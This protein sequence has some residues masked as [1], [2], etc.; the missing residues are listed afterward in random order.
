MDVIQRLQHVLLRCRKFPRRKKN[1]LNFSNLLP[2]SHRIHCEIMMLLTNYSQQ[3]TTF[4]PAWILEESLKCKWIFYVSPNGSVGKGLTTRGS[5][6]RERKTTC[7][8]E[9]HFC[10]LLPRTGRECIFVI[11]HEGIGT[12]QAVVHDTMTSCNGNALRI[13]GPFWGG[14]GSPHKVLMMCTFDVFCF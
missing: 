8:L 6:P 11:T 3:L 7:T 1:E 10:H 14:T 13:T 12:F 4:H 2:R 5:L 9:M